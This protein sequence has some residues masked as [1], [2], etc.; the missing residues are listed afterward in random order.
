MLF[1]RHAGHRHAG[2]S[3]RCWVAE[4]LA[5][6]GVVGGLLITILAIALSVA[7]FVPPG[8]VADGVALPAGLL[9]VAAVAVAASLLWIG[10]AALG[11]F[12]AE[13]I[14]PAEEYAVKLNGPRGSP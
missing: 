7:R 13:K 1:P 11:V 6:G 10:L 9:V 5:R 8:E 14:D 3:W 4:G 12:L 2:S